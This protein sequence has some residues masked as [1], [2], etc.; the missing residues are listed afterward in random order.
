MFFILLLFVCHG[1]FIFSWLKAR[2]PG[3]PSLGRTAACAVESQGT[4]W[5][6]ARISS[7]TRTWRASTATCAA[8]RATCA[9][10][11]KTRLARLLGSGKRA[12]VAAA[13]TVTPTASARA[14]AWAG[15]VG[16]ALF[17]NV[18]LQSRQQ[19]MAG[20][21]FHV[22]NLPPGSECNPTRRR[23]GSVQQYAG[24]LQVRAAGPHRARV[25]HPR[26]ADADDAP[27]WRRRG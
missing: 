10:R 22:T 14:A 9:A 21:T 27:R 4:P 15:A 18:M 1:F 12:A 13:A 6:S 7:M 20:S 5:R 26:G 24:V 3:V 25:P 8:R 23:R 2:F 19:L 16:S 17:H 11:S